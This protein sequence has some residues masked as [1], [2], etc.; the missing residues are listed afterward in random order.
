MTLLATVVLLRVY[1][2]QDHN[3]EHN[4]MKLKFKIVDHK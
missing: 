3:G 4:S 1:M 2:M